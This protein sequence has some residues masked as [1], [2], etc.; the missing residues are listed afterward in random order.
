MPQV[1][2][3]VAERLAA[4]IK[5]FQPILASA[6]SRDVGESDTVIIVTDMLSEVFGY[7]KYSEVTSETSIRG[8]WCDL[9]IKLDGA[10]EFLIEVKAIGLELKDAHTKQAVDYSANQGTDWVLLTNAEIWRVY[11]VTFAKPIDSELVLEINFSQLNPK[12]SS[13]VEL[14]YHLTREGWMKSALGEFHTQQQALSR[15]FLGA[16]VLS[17][18]VLEVI[19][20][21][22]RRLSPDVRIDIE[23]IKSALVQDVLKR[24]VVEGEKADEAR[25]KI[26]KVA[27]KLL[28]AR[29]VKAPATPEV[30]E[31]SASSDTES[32]EPQP[33]I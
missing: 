25:K 5:R 7:D 9:A 8:T 33:E 3:K 19:R 2:S 12:K 20:R 27:S 10:I 28:R 13:D 16:M 29:K 21:E 17:N 22:L 11:K 15:F 1:P 6:K 26:N 30:K 14:L 31:E 4:G 32:E 24:E 18:P 23:Q